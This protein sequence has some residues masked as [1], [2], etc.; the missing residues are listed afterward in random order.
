MKPVAPVTNICMLPILSW[1]R[2]DRADR[3]APDSGLDRPVCWFELVRLGGSAP[4]GSSKHSRIDGPQRALDTP[5]SYL[6]SRTIGKTSSTTKLSVIGDSAKLEER[7]APDSSDR[8]L[9]TPYKLRRSS[10]LSVL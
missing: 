8:V 5:G 6:V 4:S 9:S 7:A 2:V 1:P 10:S 3:A